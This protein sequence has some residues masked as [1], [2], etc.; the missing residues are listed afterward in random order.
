M[1]VSNSL[2]VA[3]TLGF[4]EQLM[5]SWATHSYCTYLK[6]G[7]RMSPSHVQH[8][9]IVFSPFP[10][11]QATQAAQFLNRLPG[12]EAQAFTAE[13]RVSVIYSIHAHCLREL[14]MQL[15]CAGFHPENTLLQKIKRA[16][17]HY[18]E[19]I[20]RHNLSISAKNTKAGMH[21]EIYVNVYDAHP[22]GD[23]ADT[24]Q[25]LRRHF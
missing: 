22:H 21:H 5:V 20:E 11:E 6:T 1:V 8:R 17:I 14:E 9:E 13:Q 10:A 24:P 15:S 23:H 16:L 7:G 18:C 3:S 12:V 19:E 2:E 25:E 4:N